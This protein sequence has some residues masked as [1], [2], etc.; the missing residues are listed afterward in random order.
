MK[1]KA[2]VSYD[3]DR[4]IHY[5]RNFEVESSL[6]EVNDVIDGDYDRDDGKCGYNGYRER[7]T[8]VVAVNLDCEQGNDEV[9]NYDYYC[10]CY[11]IEEW[12]DDTNRYEVTYDLEKYICIEREEDDEYE[13]DEEDDDY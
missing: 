2:Y 9:Y 4:C 5:Y 10:I 6:P 3:D 12:N 8:A 11:Q 13:E 1:I 7:V